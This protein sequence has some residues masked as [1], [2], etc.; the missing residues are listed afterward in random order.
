MLCG[1]QA[2]HIGYCARLRVLDLSNNNIKSLVGQG[3]QF[4]NG[5]VV[6]D[7]RHNAINSFDE[8]VDELSK[9]PALETLYLEVR[10]LLFREFRC[11][12]VNLE[13]A[14]CT[15]VLFVVRRTRYGAA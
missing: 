4:L 2:W 10:T 5:L 15:C 14:F 6:L 9:C 1:V 13:C 7:L 3:L 11:F 12:A 8:T